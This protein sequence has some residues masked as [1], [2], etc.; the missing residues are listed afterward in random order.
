[1][2]LDRARVEGA[3]VESFPV[4]VVSG[5]DGSSSSVATSA[6]GKEPDAQ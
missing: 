1:L 6:A 3:V 4:R 5:N 2:L